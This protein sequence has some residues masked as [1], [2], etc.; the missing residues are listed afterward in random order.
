MKQARQDAK[1]DGIE[2]SKPLV[3][4]AD[5][6]EGNYPRARFDADIA[7]AIEEVAKRRSPT[8]GSTWQHQVGFASEIATA[9]YFEVNANWEIYPDYVGD[10]GYD[11]LVGEDRV[12]VKAVT[13]QQDLELRVPESKVD[14][15]DYFV[16]S[17]CPNPRA[18]AQLVGWISR[19]KL[20][21]LGHRFDGDLRVGAECLSVFEPIFI[22]P[23]RIRSTQR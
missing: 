3:S 6:N 20:E 14:C 9:A 17:R 11:L 12:E 21:H 2:H 5:V 19:Q 10:E 22:P 15:A 13:A 23:E 1:N 8:L 4:A 18:L 16:L 7:W